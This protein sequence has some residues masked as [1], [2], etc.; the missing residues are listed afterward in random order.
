MTPTQTSECEPSVK[1]CSKLVS[2]T[3][4]T[5]FNDESSLVNEDSE[6]CEKLD[7]VINDE[8]HK[9]KDASN[10]SS[11]Q[12]RTRQPRTRTRIVKLLS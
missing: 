9:R 1:K 5:S 8:I 7:Q 3:S 11:L 10:G 4:D 6:G 2:R 12:Q